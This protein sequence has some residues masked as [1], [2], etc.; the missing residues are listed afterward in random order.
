MET[1]P[2]GDTLCLTYTIPPGSSAEYIIETSSTLAPG[3]WQ[4]DAAHVEE[5]SRTTNPDGSVT[6]KSRCVQPLPS[7]G[8]SFIRLMVR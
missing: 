3:S 4:S 6:V 8:K 5:V 2:S 7:A 1:G